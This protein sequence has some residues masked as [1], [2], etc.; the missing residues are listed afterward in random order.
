M[1]TAQSE[2]RHPRL[3]ARAGGK[4]GLYPYC[5]LAAPTFVLPTKR[6]NAR[7]LMNKSG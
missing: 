2:L 7:P 1:R 4:G 6:F 3:L 5:T